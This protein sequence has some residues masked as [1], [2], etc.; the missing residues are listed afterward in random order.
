M[1]FEKFASTDG[2]IKARPCF[3][4]AVETTIKQALKTLDLYCTD[5]REKFLE[6][7]YESI[8]L[9]KYNKLIGL[10]G[11][12]YKTYVHGTTQAFD[13]FHL[14]HHRKKIRVLPGEFA[15]HRISGRSYSLQYEEITEDR[16]LTR[17]DAFIL[18]IPFSASCEIPENYEQLMQTCC[19][20]GI[21]VLLDFAYL[22]ISKGIN[23]NIEYECI[24][25]ICFSLSKAYF[26]SERFRIGMRMQRS[27]TDDPIDFANE[28]NMYNLAGGHIGIE[29][30][31]KIPPSM[32]YDTLEIYANKLCNQHGYERNKTCIFGSIPLDHKM[33]ETFKRG[34]SKY[35]RICLSDMIDLNKSK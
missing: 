1:T 12:K 5:N 11:Y 16:P 15:Y 13:A 6:K 35:S 17:G 28:F 19:S 24:Q 2:G 10:N 22:G 32:I 7:Y 29:L 27:F 33:Y 3:I 30:L 26:G 20:E 4:P 25:E 18:S 31:Q 23:I 9:S 34:S 8:Y 14:K 21:P